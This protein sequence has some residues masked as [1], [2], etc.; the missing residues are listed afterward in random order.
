MSTPETT[1]S[2]TEARPASP[3]PALLEV[4]ALPVVGVVF[5]LLI[6]AAFGIG[7]SNPLVNLK[8]DALPDS[9]LPLAADLLQVLVLQYAG[10]FLLVVAILWPRRELTLRRFGLTAN[11]MAWSQLIVMGLLLAC[12][13][14]PLQIALLGAD[15]R[16]DLGD[17][18][19]WRRALLDAPRSADY[20]LLMAIGSF[21]L[22]PLLEELFYRGVLQGRL[23]QVMPPSHAI[24][25]I[26]V[27][28][29]LSHSQY[30][31][32][33]LIN[34]ATAVFVFGSSLAFGWLYWKTGSLLPAVVLHAAINV[35]W[36]TGGPALVV[37]GALLT[38]AVI[39]HRRW[40]PWLVELQRML[41]PQTIG[42]ALLAPMLLTVMFG[43]GMTQAGGV[44]VLVAALMLVTG[45]LWRWR[46]RRRGEVG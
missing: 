1:A 20:W 29:T 18:A 32:P 7:L 4:L 35:P 13:L 36:P 9:W 15:A 43:I 40:R 2:P 30:H 14:V 46:L 38:T 21:G 6:A 16:W 27:L 11:S 10:Y 24:L 34:L 25:L 23:Q 41:R 45:L 22:V 39:T 37:V 26:S 8:P 5:A 17:T 44:I 33:T 28:F 31:Q 12:L 42:R 19:P 3:W